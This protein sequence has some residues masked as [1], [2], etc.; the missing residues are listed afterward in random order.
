[1][2]C[3]CFEKF[4][5]AV[6]LKFYPHRHRD[7]QMGRKNKMGPMCK[8]SSTIEIINAIPVVESS[9]EPSLQAAKE[10]ISVVFRS[11]QGMMSALMIK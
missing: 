9:V 11:R 2:I 4:G 5:T 8:E 3:L 7:S 10:M 6:E 1:M